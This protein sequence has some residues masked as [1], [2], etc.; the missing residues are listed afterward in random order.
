MNNFVLLRTTSLPMIVCAIL[1]LSFVI[2]HANDNRR[3]LL[4]R[5][6][7]S[8]TGETTE[9]QS[10]IHI[11]LSSDAQQFR[12]MLACINSTL[13][14]SATSTHR[15]RFH[16]FCASKAECELLRRYGSRAMP[17]LFVDRSALLDVVEFDGDALASRFAR[18]S[19]SNSAARNLSVPQNYVRFYMAQLLPSGVTKVIWLDN[20]VLV[21]RDISRLFDGSLLSDRFALASVV[22]RRKFDDS[23]LRRI[24]YGLQVYVAFVRR[25]VTSIDIFAPRGNRLARR[26]LALP[27]TPSDHAR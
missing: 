16:L 25:A 4:R 14:S 15:L 26:I 23:M 21:L 8:Q 20:D 22:Q 19:L 18:G 9:A 5:Q 11:A 6:Q 12:A 1:L 10:L 2:L 3:H 27:A 13:T 7:Q 24:V 17:Q